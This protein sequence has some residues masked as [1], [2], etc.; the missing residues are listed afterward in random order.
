VYLCGSVLTNTN[1]TFQAYEGVRKFE[2]KNYLI[3]LSM[4]IFFFYKISE[5]VIKIGTFRATFQSSYY[6]QTDHKVIFK[7]LVIQAEI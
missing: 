4:L 2:L 5:K 1:T 6:L 3:N 7:L